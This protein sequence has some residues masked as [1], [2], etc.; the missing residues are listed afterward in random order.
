MALGLVGRKR[1]MT[2]IFKPDGSSVPVT[3]IDVSGNRVAQL[4]DEE[5]DGYRAAQL[6]YGSKRRALLSKGEAG[7]FARG[8][9]EPGR[10]L[11]EFRVDAD[12]AAALSVGVELPP[13]LF[14]V[15]DGVDVTGV[16]KGR[17]FAGVVRR[18]GFGGGDATHGNSLAHRA[19]GS[20]GQN[21]TP[22]RVFKGKKMAGQMG[23]VQRTQR[24]LEV[25][26]VDAERQLVMIRGSVPGPIGGEVMIRSREPVD[27]AGALGAGSEPDAGADQAPAEQSEA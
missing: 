22:G 14:S 3:V 15:G 12:E 7:H 26:A 17:G 2:R 8:G 9:V 20:I 19:P 25:A 10:G 5:R 11:K 27:V 6:T 21:Q 23:N 4:K 1:G 18:W 13:T 16:T 24:N